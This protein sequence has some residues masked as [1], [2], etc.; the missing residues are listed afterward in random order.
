MIWLVFT[1]LI[2]AWIVAMIGDIGGSFVHLLLVAALVVAAY[3]IVNQRRT[4]P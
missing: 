1:A 3:Q 2:A 4:V